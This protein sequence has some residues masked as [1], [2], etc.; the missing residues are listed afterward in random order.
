VAEEIRE[1]LDENDAIV[2][3]DYWSRSRLWK[4][5]PL[6]QT[7]TGSIENVMRFSLDDL[8]RW[9]DEKYVAQ[10][11]VVCISGATSAQQLETAKE[12]F[13]NIPSGKRAENVTT[14]TLSN[15]P[16]SLH[17]SK[18][19]SQTQ[20]RI[21]FHAPG[22]LD[23]DCVA[24]EIL[25]RTLDDG[26]ST[27]LHRRI[28]EDLGLAYNINADIEAYKD[29][30]A[31]NIDATCSHENVEAVSK[32]I[33]QII[34]NL[35]DSDLPKDA[36]I[37]AKSRAIWNLRDFQDSPGGMSSWY[38]EQELFRDVKTL[39][40]EAIEIEAIEQ[41]QLTRVARRIFTPSNLLVTTVGVQNKEQQQKLKDIMSSFV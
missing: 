41:L 7:I 21:A 26:M 17:I 31:V 1:D 34:L 37:K 32:E 9:F 4:D 20:L 39:E 35:R 3:I 28:F 2:D 18:P 16:K 30:G 27:P 36:I 22:L 11:M 23:E 8:K 5:D 33:L 15:L 38:G 14:P 40:E 6:G 12:F 19:G 10:N 24:T 13:K 29:V 25:M